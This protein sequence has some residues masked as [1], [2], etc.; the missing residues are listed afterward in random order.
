MEQIEVP[1]DPRQAMRTRVWREWCFARL[2]F[3]HF[4]VRLAILVIVLMTGGLLFRN[5]EPEKNHSLAEA[6]YFTWSLIFGEPPEEFPESVVLQ[7]L[8]FIVPLLGLVMIIEGIVDLTMMLG[9]R[10]RNERGW[11]PYDIAL[12]LKL[13]PVIKRR[14]PQ[15]LPVL[16]RVPAR[17][18]VLTGSREGM[19]KRRNVA[20]RE[21]RVLEDFA[22]DF[23]WRVVDSFE[24]PDEIGLILYRAT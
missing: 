14:V 8:F 23:D 1:V 10:R 4:R 9:D 19:V 12:M 13:I 17:C 3:R 24:T 2:A 5:F 11:C 16:G 6:T 21:R 20:G 18:L 7:S 15:G 22:R